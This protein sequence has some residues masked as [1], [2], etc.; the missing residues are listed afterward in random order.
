MLGTIQ[1]KLKRTFVIPVIILV[2]FA[3]APFTEYMHGYTY[4]GYHGSEYK[5]HGDMN[6]WV[7]KSPSTMNTTPQAIKPTNSMVVITF[8]F[9]IY[10][11]GE[12]KYQIQYII[13]KEKAS[14]RDFSKDQLNLLRNRPELN[15]LHKTKVLFS[16]PKQNTPVKAWV[17]YQS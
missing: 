13:Q 7:T 12:R 9:I 6:T 10:V 3:F 14:K 16:I 15:F 4:C 17:V 1:N 2:F 8:C 5:Y 11:F